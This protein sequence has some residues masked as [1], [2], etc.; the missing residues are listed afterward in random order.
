MLGKVNQVTLD[1]VQLRYTIDTLNIDL[2]GRL[3]QYNNDR[4]I[5]K[6]ECELLTID[7]TPDQEV[8][9]IASMHLGASAYCEKLCTYL[10]RFGTHMPEPLRRTL[11]YEVYNL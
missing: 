2:T 1:K 4:I 5:T 11:L 3:W 10:E 6:A 8:Y 7:L 9:S